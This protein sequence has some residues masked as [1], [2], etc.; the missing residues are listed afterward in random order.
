MGMVTDR[1]GASVRVPRVLK[2]RLLRDG[3]GALIVVDLEG[4]L[5]TLLPDLGT[6]RYDAYE[7]GERALR[8][9][10]RDLEEGRDPPAV[11]A[12]VRAGPARPPWGLLAAGFGLVA[13]VCAAGL[14]LG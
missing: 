2:V 12:M 8:G 10:L 13:A 9:I 3:D 4:A 6:I 5:G 1:T 14:V 7:D 11:A